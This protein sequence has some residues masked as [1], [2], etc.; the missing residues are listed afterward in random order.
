MSYNRLGIYKT[1]T[2]GEVIAALA[3]HESGA[4]VYAMASG[5]PGETVLVVLPRD[6]DECIDV[7][8]ALAGRFADASDIA[9]TIT[10]LST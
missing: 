2:V 10:K 8:E 7:A 6:V 5:K 4:H 9:V 3:K 1:A